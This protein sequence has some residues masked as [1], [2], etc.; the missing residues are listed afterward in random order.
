MVL[1]AVARV[2]RAHLPAGEIDHVLAVLPDTFRVLIT[3]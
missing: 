3:A 1:H 2:L